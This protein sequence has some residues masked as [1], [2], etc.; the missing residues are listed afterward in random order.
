MRI[1]NASELDAGNAAVHAPNGGPRP[2]G[3][4][5]AYWDACQDFGAV[6]TLAALLENNTDGG[7]Q[8][9]WLFGGPGDGSLVARRSNG[10]TDF[11]AV[12]AV[13]SNLWLFAV[14]IDSADTLTVFGQREDYGGYHESLWIR[15]YE[16][17]VGWLPEKMILGVNGE[18]FEFNGAVVD[19]TGKLLITLFYAHAEG[20]PGIEHRVYDPV[21][22]TL[23]SLSIPCREHASGATLIANPSGTAV[24]AIYAAS[25]LYRNMP[26]LLYQAERSL[27]EGLFIQRYDSATGQWSTPECI[28]GSINTELGLGAGVIVAV[29]DAGDLAVVWARCRSRNDHNVV[30]ASRMEQGAWLPPRKMA[31]L[32]TDYWANLTYAGITV[33]AAG[34]VL[35]AFAFPDSSAGINL[36][37]CRY[38]AGSGWE[39]METPLHH[40]TSYATRPALCFYEDDK[41]VVTWHEGT[42]GAAAMSLLYDGTSW[43][44]QQ[45]PLPEA[46]VAGIV[47]GFGVQGTAVLF[48]DNYTD[49][50]QYR[51]RATWLRD[52]P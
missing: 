3:R 16:Q 25:I 39:P 23:T 13:M 33:N 45:T 17:G 28:P 6:Y 38:R 44:T 49:P 22:D 29:D 48:Y 10:H 31:N 40:D 42:V 43:A 35:A 4:G 47:G 41:A 30:F 5:V 18:Y 11:G 20:S 34:D 37:T 32:N 2:A 51:S 9:A 14:V 26:E 1:S 8:H 52:A 50:D 19:D 46:S 24:Y 36:Y 27:W 15:R 21:A 7:L 12:Q